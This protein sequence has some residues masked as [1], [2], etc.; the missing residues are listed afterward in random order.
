MRGGRGALAILLALTTLVV[1]T[2]SARA[3]EIPMQALM[4]PDGTGRLFLNNGVGPFLWETCTPDLSECKKFHGGHDISTRG[5]SPGTI[6]RVKDSVGDR[7]LSPEWK[8]PLKQVTPPSVDGVIEANQFVSPVPG[9]WSGGWAGEGAEMQLSACETATGEGCTTLTSLHYLRPCPMSSSFSI[10]ARFAGKYLRVADLQPGAGPIVEPPYGL[11]SPYG[12][13]AWDASSAVSVAVV[14]QIAAAAGPP[15][16]ECGP[17]PAP[18][19]AILASGVARVEC[20]GG[21]AAT[22][23]GTRGGRQRRIRRFVAQQDLRRPRAPVE[24]HLTAASLAELG[25]GKIRLIIEVDGERLAHRTFR[26]TNS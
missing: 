15:Q 8:G 19:A 17:A 14:G 26:P 23:I 6:F 13:E 3:E 16:G 22:L 12:D 5:A 18:R 10:D 11:T 1:S 9:R 4:N 21:C 25:V 20:A 7:G 24:F 2:A